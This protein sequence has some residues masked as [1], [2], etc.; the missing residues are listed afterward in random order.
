MCPPRLL[1]TESRT[2]ASPEGQGSADEQAAAALT[3]GEWLKASRSLTP[4]QAS[5]VVQQFQR[6]DDPK[7]KLDKSTSL[8]DRLDTVAADDA[9]QNVKLR[10]HLAYAAFAAVGVQL[11]VCNWFFYLH[12]KGVSWDV[13]PAVMIAWMTGVVVET[14]GI[15]TIITINLFPNRSP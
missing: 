6:D 11:L 2:L 14:I 12:G 7:K 9:E 10:R 5:G 1:S 8:K 4:E 3:L 15:V 13:D